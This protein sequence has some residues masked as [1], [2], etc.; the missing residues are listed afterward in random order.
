MLH[1]VMLLVDHLAQPSTQVASQEGLVA[2]IG[3]LAVG[4][5]DHMEQVVLVA[6]TRLPVVRQITALYLEE[7]VTRVL[8]VVVPV[9]VER[10]GM[11]HMAAVV[12]V[13]RRY[14]LVLLPRAVIMVEAKAVSEVILA[15]IGAAR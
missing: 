9:I 11:R 12:V 10:N 3:A 14:Q 13:D 5:V 15:D 1:Q 7:L 2:T 8:P 4:L 6:L